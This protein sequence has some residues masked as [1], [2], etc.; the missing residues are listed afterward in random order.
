MHLPFRGFNK[1]EQHSFKRSN[2]S[3]VPD[4]L[5]C[6]TI[7]FLAVWKEGQK[8]EGNSREVGNMTKFY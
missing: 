8:V 7:H 3:T 6:L 5:L 1:P 2:S 4:R